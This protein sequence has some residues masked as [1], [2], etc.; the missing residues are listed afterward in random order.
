LIFATSQTVGWLAASIITANR[1][2]HLKDQ[3]NVLAL[4]SN[5]AIKLVLCCAF[6]ISSWRISVLNAEKTSLQ[7]VGIHIGLT[8]FRPMDGL[9]SGDVIAKEYVRREFTLPTEE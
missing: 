8:N 2:R 6:V 9:N 1:L 4:V 5:A 3:T 7:K